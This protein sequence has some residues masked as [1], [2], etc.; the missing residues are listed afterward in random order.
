M[1]QGSIASNQIIDKSDGII[2]ENPFGSITQNKNWP[3]K[4]ISENVDR[5]VLL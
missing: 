4:D 2:E 3:V 1:P 5:N